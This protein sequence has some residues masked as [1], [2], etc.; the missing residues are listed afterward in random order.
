MNTSRDVYNMYRGRD[1]LTGS[2]GIIGD[3]EPRKDLI[4]RAVADFGMASSW[5]ELDAKRETVTFTDAWGRSPHTGTTAST[6][7]SPRTTP[8]CS[9]SSMLRT[10]SAHSGA[11]SRRIPTCGCL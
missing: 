4:E 6:A 8:S 7:R 9:P 2:V 5:A 10:S 1:E 3:Q 11:V